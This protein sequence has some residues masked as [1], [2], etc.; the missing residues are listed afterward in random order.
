MIPC[1]LGPCHHEI[2]CTTIIRWILCVRRP[3]NTFTLMA[4]MMH[5]M[6]AA[7][8]PKTHLIH[9][10]CLDLMCVCVNWRVACCKFSMLPAHITVRR[11]YHTVAVAFGIRNK[12]RTCFRSLV[13]QN[14][15]KNR[16][17]W[18]AHAVYTAECNA[19]MN[20]LPIEIFFCLSNYRAAAPLTAIV[21]KWNENR[22]YLCAAVPLELHV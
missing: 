7:D 11:L 2:S 19:H 13:F 18:C 12:S 6:R 21:G 5:E 10:N 22:I 16:G 4:Y 3:S 20:R 15:N 8:T 17:D 1:I 14:G 9:S